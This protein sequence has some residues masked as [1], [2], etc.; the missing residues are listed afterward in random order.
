MMLT[1]PGTKPTLY[2]CWQSSAARSYNSANTSF[3]GKKTWLS[4]KEKRTFLFCNQK[5]KVRFCE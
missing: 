5:N 4:H 1:Q 3:R 2:K